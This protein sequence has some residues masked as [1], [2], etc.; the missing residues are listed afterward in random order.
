VLPLAFLLGITSSSKKLALTLPAHRL[1]SAT[2]VVS[3]L[4]LG[5]ISL[6]F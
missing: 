3:V 2:N 4:G 1:F 6:C 5:V